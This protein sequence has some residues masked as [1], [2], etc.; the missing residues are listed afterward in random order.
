MDREGLVRLK[1]YPHYLVNRKGQV[2]SEYS[3]KYIV[4]HVASTGYPQV[5]LCEDGKRHQ[6]NVHRLI[7]ET[8]IPNPDCKPCVNHK[9]EDK[10]NNAV[11]NL[12]WVT[13]RENIIYGT[14]RKRAIAKFGIDRFR[15]MQL[16]IAERRRRKVINLDTGVVYDSIASASMECGLIHSGIVSACRGRYHTCGGFHWAYYDREEHVA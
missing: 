8:F 7:A 13:Q 15:E 2:F 4:C 12:E 5:T 3:N 6:M 1:R 14:A 9:D 11:E 16:R 10:T